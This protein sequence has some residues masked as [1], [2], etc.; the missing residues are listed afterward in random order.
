MLCNDEVGLVASKPVFGVSDKARLKPVSS[1][2]ETS[3]SIEILLEAS[4][5]M[6]LSSKRITKAL[7]S[8]RGFCAGLSAPLLL[9]N[10]QS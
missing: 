6:I 10:P 4:L 2:T 7:I 5:D 8:L 9:A 3:K 1:A